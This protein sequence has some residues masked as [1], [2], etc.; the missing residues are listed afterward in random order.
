V[1]LHELAH[2]FLSLKYGLE[3]R[4]IILFVFGGIADIKEE[5]K[6]YKKEF[7]IAV[8]GPIASFSLALLFLFLW[9]MTLILGGSEAIP[10]GFMTSREDIQQ[11][12]N[13]VDQQQQQ[14]QARNLKEIIAIISGILLYSTVAN[15]L[16]GIFNLLPAFP[17]DGGRM[18]RAGLIKWN[19]SYDEA[20]KIAVRTGTGISFGLMAY[21]FIT[22][23]TGS[24]LGG[25]WFIIIGWFLQAAAQTYL[26]QHE[27]SNRL[28]SL[29]LRDIM[30]TNFIYVN[31]NLTVRQVINDYFNVY[32]KSEFP[33]LNNDGS[34]VGSI[35][36]TQIN[37]VAQDKLDEVK[38]TE[39]ISS[40][41][42][43][44]VMD[45]N[46]RA[47]LAL[48][49]IYRFNKNRIYVGY[50]KKSILDNLV[51]STRVMQI[52]ETEPLSFPS[53]SENS[54]PPQ[55][56]LEGIISKTDLLNIARSDD[57]FKDPNDKDNK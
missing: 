26:Q 16:V 5:T 36:N 38:V 11:T 15:A 32:R 50:Q 28:S 30:I 6:D 39:I 13:L 4:Q 37:S 47:D 22:I 19:K 41:N 29:Y 9:Y 33:I 1:M 54:K 2:V 8:A 48:K 49:Q 12:A 55:I 43:L 14:Q 24:T 27:I 45:K 46:S 18:L 34:L 57:K 3:V 10:S 21:G 31:S 52:K 51:N 17:L 23:F 35:S 7:K 56:K 42:D 25:F 40:V 20:T 44:I 53:I